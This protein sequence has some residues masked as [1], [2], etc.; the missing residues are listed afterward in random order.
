MIYLDYN[1]TTPLAP[2]A[3]EAMRPYL[4]GSYGNPSSIHAAGRAARAAIDDA[5][6]RLAAVLKCRPHEI[7][8][9]GGGTESDNLAVIGLAWARARARAG[10]GASAADAR[11]GGRHLITAA[12]E[13]HAVLHAFEHLE[14]H[15][16]F[17]VTRLPVD[18][19][20]QIDPDRLKSAF[21]PETTLVSIMS[22]NNETGTLQP[23]DEICRLCRKRGILFHSDMIQS[24]GKIPLAAGAG[25]G[26]GSHGAAGVGTGER[27]P[28]AISLA[29][30]KFYGPKGAGA[31]YLRAG[32]PIERLH[33]GGSHEN[34]RRPGTENV[35]A[36]AGM[37]AAAEAV[38]RNL[39][40]EQAR[41]GR[42]RDRL[43]EGICAAFPEAILNG[44]PTGRLANTLNVSF[45]GLD[46]ESLLINLDLE[47]ICASSGSA[48]MVGSVMPSH[49]L[50][51]MGVTPAL[52]GSTVRFSLG[53]P[54]RGTEIDATI[55]TLPGIFARLRPE[56]PAELYA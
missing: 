5:R 2:E 20:G 35:A 18:R 51:A 44:H 50:I 15:D 55:A 30:H 41:Q 39:E 11:A 3:A 23:L 28:D 8:F 56:P 16:G 27:G 29:A 53:K 32:T 47:G 43:W 36:I 14:K 1:A 7:I 25:G 48:C 24:F 6:D 21:T 45:P 31:L 38:V 4:E 10:A 37:A 52:A 34:E 13:H 19:H 54:T 26:G 9:T 42:L 12:T 17:R 33:F 49:V 46:G 40:T 22:A